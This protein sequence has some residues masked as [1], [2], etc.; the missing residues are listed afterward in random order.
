VVGQAFSSAAASV[1]TATAFIGPTVS[2]TVAANQKIFVSS[3]AALGASA[4]AASGLNLYI[5]Y[6]SGAINTVG[7]GSFGYTAAANQRLNFGLSAVITG[8]AAGTYIVGLCG[9]ST[10]AANWVNNEWGYTSAMVFN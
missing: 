5:C 9:S 1:T 3:H 8:L 6:Q 2:V 4:A 10:N 7:L